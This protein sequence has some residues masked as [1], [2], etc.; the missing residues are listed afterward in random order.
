MRLGLTPAC[1]LTHPEHVDRVLKDRVLF[2]R[3]KA[4]DAFRSLLGNGLLLADGDS[5]LRRRRLEQPAFHQRHVTAW[6]D[7][8]TAYTE[9]MLDKWRDGEVRDLAEDMAQLTLS[10]ITKI[11]FSIDLGGAEAGRIA[12]VMET[13]YR[14]NWRLRTLLFRISPFLEEQFP[15]PLNI[16][17]RRAIREMDSTIYQMIRQRR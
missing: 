1:L 12:D 7:I 11:L 14:M 5:W 4:W 6:G 10:I 2:V 16:R 15:T 8:V 13:A 17:Y 9:A 3:C